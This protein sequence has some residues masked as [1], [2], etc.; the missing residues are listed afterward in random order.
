MCNRL[1]LPRR[2]ERREPVTLAE[3]VAAACA[4][5]ASDKLL[6]K[7]SSPKVLALARLRE[8]SEERR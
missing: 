2:D 8:S 6:G 5:V 4:V 3:A 1:R 7:V